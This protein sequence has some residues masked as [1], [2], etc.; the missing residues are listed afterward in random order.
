MIKFGVC[1]VFPSLPATQ[2]SALPQPTRGDDLFSAIFE[3]A[4]AIADPLALAAFGIAAVLFLY[5]SYAYVVSDQ[6]TFPNTALLAIVLLVI[7][8]IGARLVPGDSGADVYSVRA[9]VVGLNGSP[10]EDA[11]VW[12]D[13]GG[14]PKRVS[15]GWEFAVP[16]ENLPEDSMMTVFAEHPATFSRARESFQL[17]NTSSVSLSLQLQRDTSAEIRGT[18][19]DETGRSIG[20]VRVSVAGYANEAVLTGQG[21]GFRLPAHAANGQQ[22]L[23]RAEKQGFRSTSIHHPAGGMPATLVLQRKSKPQ[24]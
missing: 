22:V 6:Q 14:E 17:R 15:G 10:I 21:G 12:S 3:T 20:D 19:V 11:R 7:V 23:L 2:T 13:L 5:S 4:E 16:A 24:E 18:V 9:T 8:G 1:L